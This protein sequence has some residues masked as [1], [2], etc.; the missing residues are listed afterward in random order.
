MQVLYCLFWHRYKDLLLAIFISSYFKMF[1]IAMMV[2]FANKK[3]SFLISSFYSTEEYLVGF[4][5]YL[6]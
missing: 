1:L 4:K 6:I 3:V 5:A 2:W